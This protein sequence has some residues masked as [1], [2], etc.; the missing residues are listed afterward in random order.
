MQDDSFV[1]GA[2]EVAN[3]TLG[4]D[5]VRVARFVAKAS[6]LVCGAQDIRPGRS[7][8]AV[9]LS[10]ERPTVEVRFPRWSVLVGSQCSVGGSEMLP[11]VGEVERVHNALNQGWLIE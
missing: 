1:D 9:E 8:E 2:F 11:L 3:D 7:R 6:A 10:D 5:V 4:C